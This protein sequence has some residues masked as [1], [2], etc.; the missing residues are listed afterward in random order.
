[1]KTLNLYHAVIQTEG[2]AD[3]EEI[4]IGVINKLS[5]RERRSRVHVA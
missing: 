1:M 2:G 4:M 5:L 3:A